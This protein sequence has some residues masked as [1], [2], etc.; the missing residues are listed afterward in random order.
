[1]SRGIYKCRT[2]FI[3]V[4]RHLYKCHSSFIYIIRHLMLLVIYKCRI[5]TVFWYKRRPIIFMHGSYK[6]TMDESC[7]ILFPLCTW[8]LWFAL[9]CCAWRPAWRLRIISREHLV[10]EPT[11]CLVWTPD[12]SGCMRMS[13]EQTCLEVSC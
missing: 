4:A 12:T 13:G 8:V 9:W 6:G 1:M 3:N 11:K 7:I 2:L 5:C 10:E